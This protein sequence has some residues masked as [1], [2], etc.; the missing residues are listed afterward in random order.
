LYVWG[1][2]FC[3]GAFGMDFFL[4]GVVRTEDFLTRIR[5][6]PLMYAVFLLLKKKEVASVN[7]S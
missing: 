4:D 2:F 6:V 3:G 1:D 7:R 5:V